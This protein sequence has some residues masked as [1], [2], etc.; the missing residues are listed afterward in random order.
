MARRHD[1]RGPRARS[2]SAVALLFG[3]GLPALGLAEAERESVEDAVAR[4]R[5]GFEACM[6]DLSDRA[7]GAGI[8]GAIVDA[9]VASSEFIPRIVELDRAQPE[10]T[11]TFADYYAVRVS[12]TRV[13]RGREML[14]EHRA[15]LEQV[16]DASGVP[17]QYLVAFWGLETNFGSYFG[18]TSVPSALATL[19]CEGRRASFFTEQWLTALRILEAGDITLERMEG[20]WAGAMGHVQFMPTTF[21]RHAVDGDGDG[22]RDLWGSLPDAFASAGAFLAELGW[23]PGWRWG[24]EVRLPEDFDHGIAGRTPKRPLREFAELGVTLADGRPLPA[25]D[26]PAGLV[27]PHG[28]QGPAFVVYE[29]FDVIMGWNRSEYYALAVGRLADRI[30]GAGRLARPAQPTG[31]RLTRDRVRA[32]QQALLDAG[33]DPGG[34]DG[35]LGGGTRRALRSWQRSNGRTPDGF[36]D[37]AVFEAFGID[38]TDEERSAG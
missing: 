31:F 12:D 17:P 25:L 10:F 28:A 7:R 16:R 1:Y 3:L 21:T 5:A 29:N 38:T 22:R 18:K 13:A 2:R 11:R 9:A 24:R 33:H 35:I 32:L 19:A 8:D 23:E 15:L 36:A 27:I 4:T 34:V 30:A 6:A 26:V 14:V 37:A 20:S